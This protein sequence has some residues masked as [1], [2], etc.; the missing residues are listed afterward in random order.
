MIRL[1]LSLLGEPDLKVE[2]TSGLENLSE[3]DLREYLIS[4]KLPRRQRAARRGG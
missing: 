3:D 1:K 4:G 2:M